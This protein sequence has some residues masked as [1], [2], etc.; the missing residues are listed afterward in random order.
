[1]PMKML[2]SLLGVV[3]LSNAQGW[4]GNYYRLRMEKESPIWTIHGLWPEW[5]AGF[6]RNVTFKEALVEDL[7]PE[8]NKYWPSD[9]G[10]NP[11]FWS[12][13]WEKHGSCADNMTEHQYFSTALSLY[14]QT[15]TQ[16][17]TGNQCNVCFER[18]LA[19]PKQC[20]CTDS[21][22]GECGKQPLPFLYRGAPV[23]EN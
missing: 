19:T 16:C 4:E 15:H 1:M 12:H 2:L 21:G 8:L 23:R 6:C 10:P 14:N 5:N 3:A 22:P 7:V 13:E 20:K 18:N 11:T 9:Q 17:T